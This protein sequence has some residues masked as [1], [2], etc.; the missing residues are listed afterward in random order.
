MNHNVAYCSGMTGFILPQSFTYPS[1]YMNAGISD[2]I[3]GR[4]CKFEGSKSFIRH[5]HAM[6]HW[7]Q[8]HGEP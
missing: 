1:E 8:K 3:R 7:V 4:T 2:R 5:F 6:I